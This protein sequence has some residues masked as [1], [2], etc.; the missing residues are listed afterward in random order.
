MY[1][2]LVSPGEAAVLYPFA[3]A[4][5]PAT[6]LSSA[7]LASRRSYG[8]EALTTMLAVCGLRH[9]RYFARSGCPAARRELNGEMPHILPPQPTQRRRCRDPGSPPQQATSGL[10]GD[11]GTGTPY[12]IKPPCP[13]VRNPTGRP[14]QRR[15][16]DAGRHDVRI[17]LFRQCAGSTTGPEVS[18][19]RFIGRIVDGW[20]WGYP[21]KRSAPINTGGYAG[22]NHAHS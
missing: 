21:R 8:G 20:R 15:F 4:R 18:A 3:L 6:E 22:R 1:T 5:K 2:G 14:R 11:P 16:R 19:M 17:V 13:W 9:N 12:G 7:Q 10:V